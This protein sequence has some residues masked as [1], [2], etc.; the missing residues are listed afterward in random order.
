[1]RYLLDT[2]T[3]LWYTL[4][5]GSLS[6]TAIETIINN[7]NKI[8]ISPASYWEIAIKISIGKLSLN[9]PYE[10]F[11]DVCISKYNFNI[12]P[13]LPNH[14]AY[15]IKLLFH[16]KDPFDRLLIA[17]AISEKMPL[18]SV[19]KKFDDYEISRIW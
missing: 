19:D 11:I 12:L 5:E 9:Q 8:F 16:H 2:H 10:K 3:L 15:L 6:S 18:I 17:Q 7:Q 1:M 13:I 4:G 14:T